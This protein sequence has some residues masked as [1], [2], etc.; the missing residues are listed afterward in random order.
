MTTGNHALIKGA[1]LIALLAPMIAQGGARG[2]AR[3]LCQKI[4]AQIGPGGCKVVKSRKCP[5]PFRY[6]IRKFG[7]YKVC[8]KGR[9]HAEWTTLNRYIRECESR[10]RV[11]AGRWCSVR[12]ISQP[13]RPGRQTEVG[14]AGRSRVCQDKLRA[15][16]DA[17]ASC[18]IME[19]HL[20]ARGGAC[21]VTHASYRCKMG[22]RTHKVFGTGT[23][24]WR[25]CVAYTPDELK[26]FTRN[27][28]SLNRRYLPVCFP[29]R[30][31]KRCP[32]GTRA[33]KA[34]YGLDRGLSPRILIRGYQAC[35]MS[36]TD[37]RSFLNR[38]RGICRT[39]LNR[40]PDG[41]CR[42][43]EKNA[44]CPSGWKQI[45]A[46]KPAQAGVR[47][48]GYRSIQRVLDKKRP[49][50]R[51]DRRCRLMPGRC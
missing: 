34:F 37:Y 28:C 7:K 24:S 32:S 35:A 49:N 1:L 6:R 21:Y 31:N 22:S 5:N 33:V 47:V 12:P 29:V 30:D 36:K 3:A 9:T 39:W 43:V 26:K 17:Y 46:M 44:R 19:P 27:Y 20:R 48:C 8:L 13:C 50:V 38:A 45:V 23:Y 14:T 4:D 16:K 25:V 41:K 42:V 18:E 2:Q 40:K 11:G 10:K 51:D 15:E